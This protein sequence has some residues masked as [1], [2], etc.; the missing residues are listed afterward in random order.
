MAMSKGRDESGCAAK[1]SRREFIRA[2]ALGVG[3]LVL[4]G[5]LGTDHAFARP[6]NA[7]KAMRPNFLFIVS[8]QQQLSSLSAY[9]CP[10]V[11][12]PHLDRLAAR[13]V[14]FMESHSTNPICSPAR[15]SLFTG[16]MPVETG[17][18]DNGR[19]IHPSIPNMG[20]WFGRAGYET[21]YCG[22]WH[23]S[24]YYTMNIPGFTVLPANGGQG[25]LIDTQVTHSCEAWLRNRTSKD[26]Y[27]LTANYLQPHDICFWAIQHEALVPKALPFTELA[28][29]LPPLPPN[30]HSFPA[31]PDKLAKLRFKKF[32]EIQ[33]RYYQYIYYR[34]V[35]MLDAEVG[36]LLEALEDSGQAENTI[37]IFTSDHG[38][39]LGRHSVTGKWTP[40]EESVKV[41]LIVSCPGRLPEG[42]RDETHLVSGVDIMSTMCDFAG[43]KPPRG[44]CGRSLRPIMADRPTEWR[45]FVV[46]EMQLTGRML[47]TRDYKYVAYQGDPVEQL[48]DM[49]HDPW[50]TTNLYEDARYADTLKSHRRLLKEWEAKIKPVGA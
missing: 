6:T 17:V 2:G 34:Q 29:K 49:K 44:L 23:I 9:G 11:K 20:Q 33:W 14:S 50:E 37:V 10:W 40:Y 1:I 38:E 22:K 41:P 35:E 15:S 3:G 21:V 46:A 12:T 30:C 39:G 24:D 28:D 25:D 19:T 13:G 7:T 32:N 26:P 47:R 31:A 4:G 45:E 5:A 27:V 18:T 36:R 42:R 16:R 48:F 8:D 43:V